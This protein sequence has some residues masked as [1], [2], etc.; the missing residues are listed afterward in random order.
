MKI[1]IVGTDLNSILTAKY[2]KMQN[3]GHDIYVTDEENKEPEIYTGIAIRENET[4]KLVDFV[5]YNAIE[6]TIVNSPLAIINGIADEFE[7]EGFPIFAPCGESARITFFNSIAKKIMYKLKI[8]TAKFGIFDRENMATDY[9]RKAMFPIA[10]KN[11]FT[12]MERTRN[13]YKNFTQAKYGIQKTFENDNDKIVIENH[14]DETPIYVYFL[15]DGYNAL[16]LIS[17][18][19]ENCKDCIITKSTSE[20][21]TNEVLKKMLNQIVYPLLDDITKFS[22]S[23]KGI[24][25]LKVKIKNGAVYTNEFYNGFQEYDMQNFLAL[26]NEDLTDILYSSAQGT[27]GEKYNHIELRNEQAFTIAIKKD[28]LNREIEEE[29]EFTESEDNKRYAITA[30]GVTRN[31]AKDKIFEYLEGRIEENILKEIRKREEEKEGR[32]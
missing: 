7:K 6:F 10:V 29:N 26:L 31:S 24:L 2:I 18:E 5:K 28:N 9:A 3:G 32:I 4:E 16:P 1:L 21:I 14:I 23:Y 30:T 25:G 8:P 13:V 17:T 12:L 20:K 19:R 11:D 27:L 15:T 22:Q